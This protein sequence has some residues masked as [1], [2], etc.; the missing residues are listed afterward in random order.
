VIRI[1]MPC[2]VNNF[3]EMLRGRLIE[4]LDASK[5]DLFKNISLKYKPQKTWAMHRCNRTVARKGGETNV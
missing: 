2:D 1:A 3:S 4:I 5:T